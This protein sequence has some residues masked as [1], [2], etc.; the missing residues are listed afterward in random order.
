MMSSSARKADKATRDFH[1]WSELGVTPLRSELSEDVRMAN[2]RAK[3]VLNQRHK[4]FEKQRKISVCHLIKEKLHMVG[5][6]GDGDGSKI[7][8]NLLVNEDEHEHKSDPTI[9]HD[10]GATTSAGLKFHEH[11]DSELGVMG[12]THHEF[13]PNRTIA[14]AETRAATTG[15]NMRHQRRHSDGSLLD[16]TQDLSTNNK[17]S[18]NRVRTAPP[19]R[20]TQ[21]RTNLMQHLLQKRPKSAF[22]RL[23]QNCFK[24]GPT[25]KDVRSRLRE[26]FSIPVEERWPDITREMEK[27]R[28]TLNRHPKNGR[29]SESSSLSE[30]LAR[31]GKSRQEIE[32]E[33]K[34]LKDFDK[35]FAKQM[36]R[37]RLSD[38]RRDGTARLLGSPRIIEEHEDVQQSASKWRYEE[39]RR[40]LLAENRHEQEQHSVRMKIFLSHLEDT[41]YIPKKRRYMIPKTYYE[42]SYVGMTFE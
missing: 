5:E 18:R 24:R 12:D 15:I 35:E 6:I 3:R 8:L 42:R 13:M 25:V 26:E 29:T 17:N 10:S 21:Q 9:S 36:A 39:K 7:Q 19:Y 1:K 11:N 2:L 34:D 4:L 14:F 28:R 32:E 31:E 38:T 22:E 23:S 27:R 16:V 33:I 37:I 40:Y 20:T 41:G 30:G